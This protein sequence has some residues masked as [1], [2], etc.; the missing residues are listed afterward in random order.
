[1]SAKRL[2]LV[3]AVLL[4]VALATLGSVAYACTNLAT[5]NLSSSAGRAGEEVTITG[6]SFRVATKGPSN[7]V[8]LHWNAV[9][10]PVLAEVVPDSAGNI[11]ATITVPEGQPGY[12]VLVAT[13]RTADGVDEYG[14][15]ARAAFQIVGPAGAPGAQQPPAQTPATVGTDPSSTGIIVITAAL[16]VLGLALFGAGFIAFV[17]QP[18]ARKVPAAAPVTREP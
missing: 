9:E 8:Q 17:R 14:T 1:M 4:G 2:C 13:Q 10:G 12:Y 7:P 3:G 6:S 15:P 11:S 16:G 18:S 5:L